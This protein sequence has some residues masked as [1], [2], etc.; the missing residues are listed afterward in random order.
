MNEAMEKTQ[1][2]YST[3]LDIFNLEHKDIP[4]TKHQLISMWIIDSQQIIEKN[5]EGLKGY[6]KEIQDCLNEIKEFKI[7][8]LNGQKMA[9]NAINR[10]QRR[11]NELIRSYKNRVTKQRTEMTK[12]ELKNFQVVIDRANRSL[13][14]LEEAKELVNN[15]GFYFEKLEII[16]QQ[17]VGLEDDFS[18][19]ISN[20]TYEVVDK[21]IETKE[22][23]TKGD[24]KVT[25]RYN[26][27]LIYE[28]ISKISML[29]GTYYALSYELSR[30]EEKHPEFEILLHDNFEKLKSKI[31]KIERMRLPLLNIKEFK[32]Y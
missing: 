14:K 18:G 17:L 32:K 16:A 8:L 21:E 28:Q 10:K 20:D 22:M 27:E 2:D 12:E 30:I 13:E 26:Y 15:D 3:S 11:E 6:N 1:Y 7:F 23:G 31:N 24:K 25:T 9:L 19:L 29:I 4:N 5:N